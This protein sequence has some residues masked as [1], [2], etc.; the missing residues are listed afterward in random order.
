MKLLGM[1]INNQLSFNQDISNISKSASNQLWES[2]YALG[3]LKTFL[4]FKSTKVLINTFT[5]S[6]FSHCPL[7]CFILSTKS[8]NK[9]KLCMG[10]HL[11]KTDIRILFSKMF[12]KKAFSKCS[13]RSL[14]S[15]TGFSFSQECKTSVQIFQ[16]PRLGPQKFN[17]IFFLRFSLQIQ[18]LRQARGKVKSDP[19]S[20]KAF[21]LMVF[22]TMDIISAI[23]S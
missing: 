3:R 7:V 23:Q 4:I 22:W 17:E 6:N 16:G 5:L 1:S 10:L 19:I 20:K 21:V 12:S 14:F 13:F 18:Q 8:L 2:H 15:T 11:L 9:L